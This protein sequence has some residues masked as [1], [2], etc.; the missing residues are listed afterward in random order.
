MQVGRLSRWQRKVDQ[1]VSEII[2]DGDVSHL[3]GAGKPLP[4]DDPHVPPDMRAAYKI[5]AD[6]DVAPDWIAAG[7]ALDSTARQL[8]EQLAARASRYL[9]ELQ[10]A[11]AHGDVARQ[12]RIDGRWRR[13]CDDY[14]ERVEKYNREAL[15]YNLK[16]PAGL[17][18]RQQLRADY[19]IAKA[20]EED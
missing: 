1:G 9:Q 17:P 12:T 10:S 14:R 4:L 13:F 16:L 8:Q 11:R 15:T 20:L 5:M 6:N 7:K 2:G 3:P 18:R 19:Q